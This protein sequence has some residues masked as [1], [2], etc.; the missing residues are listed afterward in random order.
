MAFR[1]AGLRIDDLHS[2][3]VDDI[4]HDCRTED[5]EQTFGK[6]GKIMDTYIPRDFHTHKSRGFAFVRYEHEDEAKDAADARTEVGG[7]P[8]KCGLAT[9][10]KPHGDLERGGRSDRERGGGRGRSR[11]DSRRRDDR[12]G[13]GGGRRDSRR[14]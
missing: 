11:R 9:R 4:P 10:P 12:R 6:Y 5:L 13:G 1:Q 14:R 2:V 7:Q 3:K 8:V